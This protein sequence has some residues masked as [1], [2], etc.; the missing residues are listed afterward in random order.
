M[1]YEYVTTIVPTEYNHLESVLVVFKSKVSVA[2]E[3]KVVIIGKN[4]QGMVGQD[5]YYLAGDYSEE[6][7]LKHIYKDRL[8]VQL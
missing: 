5:K 3:Y 4:D 6:E 2:G 7:A 8:G 1:K